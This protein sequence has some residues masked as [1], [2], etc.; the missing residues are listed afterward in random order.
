MS[1]LRPSRF[2]FCEPILD[3]GK[4]I[5]REN[6]EKWLTIKTDGIPGNTSGFAVFMKKEAP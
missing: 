6:S 2:L 1:M 3:T 4:T 5:E